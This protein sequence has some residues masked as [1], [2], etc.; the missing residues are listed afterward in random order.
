[1]LSATT[2]YLDASRIEMVCPNGTIIKLNRNEWRVL[3]KFA[4]AGSGVVMEEKD[5]IDVIPL[6]SLS[7]MMTILRSKLGAESILCERKM[8]YILNDHRITLQP[9]WNF[10]VESK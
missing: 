7:V 6:R 3:M 4:F 5:F 2:Y 1:M 10:P 8:G 9:V